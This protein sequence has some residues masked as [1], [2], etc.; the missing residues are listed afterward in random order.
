M[1]AYCCFRVQMYILFLNW[2]TILVI[3][4]T[5]RRNFWFIRNLKWW[6][7]CLNF[8]NAVSVHILCINIF[9]EAMGF[10]FRSCGFSTPKDHSFGLERALL[11]LRRYGCI[12]HNIWTYWLIHTENL[13]K[14]SMWLSHIARIICVICFINVC[15][16]MFQSVLFLFWNKMWYKSLLYR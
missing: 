15:S 9:K 10:Q 12:I 7:M 1:S 13:S 2:Q 11:L 16:I 3:F 8:A 14:L 5:Y 6:N 4:F